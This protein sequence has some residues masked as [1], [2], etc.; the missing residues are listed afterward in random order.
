MQR[1]NGLL[2][3]R[4]YRLRGWHAESCNTRMA[5]QKNCHAAYGPGRH[6]PCKQRRR[7]TP[8]RQIIFTNITTQA[9]TATPTATAALA[10]TV[11][12][13]ATTATSPRHRQQA[14]RRSC[15]HDH[16][17]RNYH[18]SHNSSDNKIIRSCRVNV[19]IKT[20]ALTIT[21]NNTTL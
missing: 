5:S 1:Q 8:Q 7:P 20:A 14:T 10:A 4:P 18:D 15:R 16:N 12:A 17:H 19:S 11:A 3:R 6:L 2:I 13:I 9:A 21:D